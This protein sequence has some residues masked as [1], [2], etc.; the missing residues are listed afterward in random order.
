MY[1]RISL[2]RSPINAITLIVD[3]D[4]KAIEERREDFPLPGSEKTPIRCPFPRVKQASIA[5]IPVG[6]T[7]WIASAS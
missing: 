7:S 2:P 3:F 6:N 1:S 4:P 5:L